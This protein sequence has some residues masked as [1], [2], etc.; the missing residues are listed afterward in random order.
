MTALI[1]R[2]AGE[3][4]ALLA[5]GE[6]TAESV[7]TAYL[8]AIRSREPRVR[9]FLAIDEPAALNQAKEFHAGIGRLR[10]RNAP[11]LR[12]FK[13]LVHSLRLS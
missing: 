3:L 13:G 5:R 2:T 8:D 10:T 7:T 6:V 1:E 4:S 9:A 11:V 12:D